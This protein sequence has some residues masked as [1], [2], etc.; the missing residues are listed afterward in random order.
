[1]NQ[2]EYNTCVMN[3]SDALYRFVLKNNRNR[4]DAQDVVQHSFE[5]LW[6]KRTEVEADKAKSFL[7]TIGYRKMIDEIRKKKK[8]S[9]HE[10][11]PDA[12]GGVTETKEVDLKHRLEKALEE[13]PAIQKQLVLLKDY[14]GYSYEELANI[15]KLNESQVKVY[16]FRARVALKKTLISIETNI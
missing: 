16:L 5:I 9:L 14:E 8:L 15:T 12:W 13:L 4:D 3:H 6:T 11:M 10:E 1:M 7:F 2:N